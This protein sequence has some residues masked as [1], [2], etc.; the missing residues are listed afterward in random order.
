LELFL[1]ILNKV[2][3]IKKVEVVEEEE[4][5]HLLTGVFYMNG[6]IFGVGDSL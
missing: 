5:F 3:K 1:S 6:L 4:Y 2:L